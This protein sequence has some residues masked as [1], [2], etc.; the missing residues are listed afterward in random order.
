MRP[1]V[2]PIPYR[3][4][5]AQR[6]GQWPLDPP[7]STALRVGIKRNTTGRTCGMPPHDCAYHSLLISPRPHSPARSPRRSGHASHGRGR[8]GRRRRRARPRRRRGPRR[9]RG[10]PR[11]GNRG[12]PAKDPARHSDTHARTRASQLPNRRRH[13]R[14]RRR[15]DPLIRVPLAR[16]QHPQAPQRD[17]CTEPGADVF[18]GATY[19]LL[20]PEK[21]ESPPLGPGQTWTYVLT[22]SPPS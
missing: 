2:R 11:R 10:G 9:D 21:T 20:Q 8:R 5:L 7:S 19:P 12:G 13:G 18:H 16:E 3:T 4:I 17:P 22:T 15:G 1:L 14:S 6:I